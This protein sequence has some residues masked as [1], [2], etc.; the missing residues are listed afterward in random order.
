MRHLLT[1]FIATIIAFV[2]C[3]AQIKTPVQTDTLVIRSMQYHYNEIRPENWPFKYV[4]RTASSFIFDDQEFKIKESE[5]IGN[6]RSFSLE[7]ANSWLRQT[8]TLTELRDIVRLEFDGYILN[9]DNPN[10]P[11]IVEDQVSLTPGKKK[12]AVQLNGRTLD[13]ALPRPA[14]SVPESGTVVVSI[15]VD[16]YGKVRKA[17][18]GAD[19]TTVT[20]SELWAA[21]RKA[22]LETRFNMDSDAPKLQQGSIT[23]I[24]NL[25]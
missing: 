14:Y 24:F 2:C 4:I 1:T 18:A 8:L 3:N 20:D 5:A 15:W 6:K 21:A 17:V 22:A 16:N 23:Y 11:V 19:G 25:K 10:K 7:Y 13:G 9:C 12:S